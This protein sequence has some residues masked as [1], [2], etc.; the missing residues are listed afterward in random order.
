MRFELI[1]KKVI[2]NNNNDG[3]NNN[4]NNNIN[5]AAVVYRKETNIR[6]RQ[7]ITNIK[8]NVDEYYY[9]LITYVNLT[10][11]FFNFFKHILH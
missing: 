9:E 7:V 6:E 2:N 11:L 10:I 5:F 3:G 1:K 8:N 4:N